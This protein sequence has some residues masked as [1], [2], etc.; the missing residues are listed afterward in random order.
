[1]LVPRS[2]NARAADIDGRRWSAGEG[3]GAR[4]AVVA[5][6]D[7]D[8][9]SLRRYI[10]YH[11]RYDPER[12]ERRNVVVAA[13]D[14]RR[15]F[16]ACFKAES[17]ALERRRAVGEQLDP[18]EHVSGTVREPGY[19][20]RAANGRLVTRALGHGVRPGP[21]LDE[22]E[23]PSNMAVLRASSEPNQRRPKPSLNRL[24][25]LVA[26]RDRRAG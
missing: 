15:E 2:R 12:H 11:Y 14:S 20:Q 25:R 22:L 21:W 5:R 23:M 4:L 17:V 18:S 7:P 13:F 10:V 26:R 1:M 3:A 24:R 16:N 6:V 8:D 19:R 9:D